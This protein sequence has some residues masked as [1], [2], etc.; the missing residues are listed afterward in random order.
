DRRTHR[1][2]TQ[3]RFRQLALI[4]SLAE[5]RS[6][7]LTAERLHITAPAVSS[8]VIEVEK[9]LGFALFERLPQGMRMTPAGEHFV[10]IAKNILD[11]IEYALTV[12]DN[13]EEGV[14]WTV[15]VGT[16][17]TG[18]YLLPGLIGALRKHS[19]RLRVSHEDRR[20][21][22]LA[23]QLQLGDLDMMIF[24]GTEPPLSGLNH[25]SVV[26]LDLFEEKFVVVGSP[27]RCERL[28]K[29]PRWSALTEQ[30]WILPPVGVLQRQI[31]DAIIS[32]QGLLPL[33]PD[34]ETVSHAGAVQMASADIGLTVLPLSVVA[35]SLAAGTL[36]ACEIDAP[37]P[38]VPVKLAY[39]SSITMRSGFSGLRETIL[40]T[41]V[42]RDTQAAG[43]ART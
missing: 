32:E 27:Q 35:S 33:E 10:R 2:I 40:R 8:N 4:C 22:A 14:R 23:E 26:S 7:R 42:R 12:A 5:T 43:G 15:R 29:S 19:A 6:L 11:E 16:S 28:G 9:L 38:C 36:A 1:L 17:Y 3:L 13:P 31:V 30:P 37:L 21:F 18:A 34:V 25:P 20:V 41:L 39:R 24:L